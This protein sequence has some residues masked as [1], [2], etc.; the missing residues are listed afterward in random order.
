MENEFGDKLLLLNLQNFIVCFQSSAAL[1]EMILLLEDFEI[2]DQW[3]RSSNKEYQYLI[4]AREEENE[5]DQNV[6]YKYPEALLKES[7]ILRR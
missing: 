1:T 7:E 4:E 5:I 3:S 6:R 2:K